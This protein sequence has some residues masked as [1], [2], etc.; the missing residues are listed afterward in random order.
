[1]DTGGYLPPS[2]YYEATEGLHVMNDAALF[3]ELADRLD[4]IEKKISTLAGN[5]VADLWIPKKQLAKQLGVSVR[6]LDYR[7]AEGLP[8]REIA[9]RLVFRLPQ[10]ESWLRTRGLIK[11]TP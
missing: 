6:W 7:V 10:V 5:D 11:E 8:H 3:Y 9:G 2:G 4:R 1:V